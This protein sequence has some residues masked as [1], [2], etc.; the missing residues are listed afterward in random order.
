MSM[1]SVLIA[2]AGIAG[3]T[4]AYWLKAAGFE[5]AIVERAPALRSSGYVIDFWGLGYDLAE[6]MGL[7]GEINRVGYHARE[8]R[9]INDAGYRIAGFGTS[10]FSELTGGRYV[11]LPRSALSGLLFGKV[12]DSIET[13]FDDEIVALEEQTDCV[14]VVLKHVGERRFDLLVGADGLHSSVRNLTFGPQSRFEKHLGYAVA[15]FETS[16]YRPRDED[17]YLM[18][19][20]PGRM[21]GR[22]ALHDN[23]TLFLFVFATSRPE[24]PATLEAQKALLRDV[25][26]QGGWECRTI[27]SELD[28]TSE[29]YFD[30]VSQIRMQNWSRGRIAL[31]GDAAFCVSLLA[32]QGSALA[33]IAAYVLAGELSASQGQYQ[34]AFAN[35]ENSATQL[36]RQQT[37][38]R[39]ALCRCLCAADG[40]RTAF[41][42]YGHQSFRHSRF[43]KACS[44]QRYCR[45]DLAS[46]LSLAGRS[47]GW[48]R[49][50]LFF[51]DE[52]ARPT[53]R[54]APVASLTVR[55][56]GLSSDINTK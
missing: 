25:Y 56:R 24:L 48:R 19:G 1:K 55:R 20:E 17:I 23:R 21:L 22:F 54:E 4:L 33:M 52:T 34:Q 51:T 47:I 5:P 29:L 37:A 36:R 43:C 18:Y 31:V 32:G 41:P 46:Q 28:G 42:Q 45:S 2:G 35:Y 3:P 15:A 13:I 12:K 39:R 6:H 49:A 9:I 40:G 8:L 14:R 27:L 50:T 10:V 11:T 44:R 16:G 38:R 26:G 53:A 30:S 7:I